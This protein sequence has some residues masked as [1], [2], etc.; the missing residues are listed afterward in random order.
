MTLFVDPKIEPC[1]SC[2]YSEWDERVLK[3]IPE[4]EMESF[5]RQCRICG[6]GEVWVRFVDEDED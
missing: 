6:K 3:R 2:Y 5:L 4:V 1:P